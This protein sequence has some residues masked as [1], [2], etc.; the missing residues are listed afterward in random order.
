MSDVCFL[1]L[2]KQGKE[3]DEKAKLLIFFLQWPNLDEFL[4]KIFACLC[5]FSLHKNLRSLFTKAKRKK[6][7]KAA[8]ASKKLK[9]IDD[10]I[11]AKALHII[12]LRD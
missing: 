4:Y 8:C 1:K 5:K 7:L 12:I 9:G 11:Y 6:I 2:A 10:C 3:F